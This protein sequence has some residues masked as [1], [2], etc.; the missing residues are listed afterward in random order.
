MYWEFR[1]G[2]CKQLHHK[3]MDNKVLLYSTEKYIQ[4][5]E[6]NLNGKEYKKCLYICISESLCCTA[7]TATTV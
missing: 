5:P 2:R 6:I 7:E 1:V 4:C 3:W